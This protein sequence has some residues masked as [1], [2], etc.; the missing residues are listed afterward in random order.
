MKKTLL[1]LSAVIFLAACNTPA[2]K[3]KTEETPAT[4]AAALP[5]NFYKKLKGKIGENMMITVDLIKQHDSLNNSNSLE[6]HYYYDKVG[7][8]LKL[9]G[10]INDSGK[11]ELKEVNSN[12]D[13]TG[14]FDGQFISENQA[15]GTW[16][17]PKNKKQYPFEI[18]VSEADNIDFRFSEYYNQNCKVADANLK[19]TKKDTLNWFDT[20]CVS[21][22]ISLA[23]LAGNDKVSQKI[24]ATLIKQM[25]DMTGG[26]KPEGSIMQFLHSIDNAGP[27]DIMEAEY[28]S[29]IVSNEGNVLSMDVSG[30]Q[31]TGGAHP[32]GFWFLLNFDKR[33]GDTISLLDVVK[34]ETID[35]LVYR[36]KEQFI[37]ENGDIKENGWFWDDGNFF[38]SNNFS[39]GKGGLH[40]VYQ[41]YEAGPYAM[42]MPEFFL[43]WSKI[44]D[45][46]RPEYLK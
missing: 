22:H 43:P 10:T 26:E 1:L 25:L 35:E 2:S 11:F 28:S 9:Y 18:K 37:K 15:T 23:Y 41:A 40:F 32:N 16:T 46:V 30:W 42:G 44:K 33:T 24:N 36:G 34:P 38:L 5:L 39:I 3:E 7:M 12:G 19:S 29:G 6:G 45:I 31:N 27:G 13:N 14:L 4:G 21:V 8:P 20:A 17:N